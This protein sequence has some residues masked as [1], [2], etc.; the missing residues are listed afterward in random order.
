MTTDKEGRRSDIIG[1]WVRW[2]F[3]LKLGSRVAMLERLQF[4]DGGSIYPEKG[5]QKSNEN[6]IP[7]AWCPSS[8][9]VAVCLFTRTSKSCCTDRDDRCR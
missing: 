7:W 2:Y 3:C 8:K 4:F 6:F 9:H 5:E 1:I